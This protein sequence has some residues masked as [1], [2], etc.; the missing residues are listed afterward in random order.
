M[1]RN[2]IIFIILSIVLFTALIYSNSFNVPFQFDDVKR[3]VGIKAAQVLN[4]KEIF[5][6]SKTR[7]LLYL[8][9]ALNFHFGHL[10]VFGYHVFNLAVHITAS[11][12]VFLLCLYIFNSPKLAGFNFKEHRYILSFFSALI[13][14][15]HPLQTQAVTYIWQR[16]ESMAGM[17]YFLSLVLYA[18]FR[19]SQIYDGDK[20]Q[21][22]L[23]YLTCL[24]S[25][26]L[27]SLTKPTSITLPI[28]ILL[29]EATFFS[30]N[31]EDFKKSLKFLFPILLL[32]LFPLLLAKFDAGENKGVGIRF[33]SYYMPY[34]YTKLRVLANAFRLMF[35]PVGQRLEYDFIL[36]ASLIKPISTFYSLIFHAALII[37]AIAAFKRYPFLSFAI[38][39]FYLTLIGTTLL[40]LDQYHI[41]F[42]HYLYLTLF[43]YAFILPILILNLTRKMHVGKKWCVVALVIFTAAYSV[44]SYSRNKVWQT[45]ISLWEDAV[46]KSPCS[47]RANYTLGVYYFR[48][49]RF[50]EALKRYHLALQYRPA[51]AEAYYRLGEYYFG[52][53]DAEKAVSNYKRALKIKPDF[54]EAYLNL[55]GVYLYLNKYKDA[56]LC[57]NN[58]LRFTEDSDYIRKINTVIKELE[59]YE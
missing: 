27:C 51:Y 42:E 14:A 15:V 35:L 41:F 30:K 59:R 33:T 11:L 45:E 47:A 22:N 38:T 55:G 9:L 52:F 54:F 34:Y 21:K 19:L 49:K 7:F 48:A 2:Y 17:F 57:Y 39:W 16:G 31:S 5:Q 23:L 12:I 56:R 8:T 18:K 26:I 36:S 43:G 44:A 4:I 6:Y 46:R 53:G 50:K 28:A 24:G 58:A 40:Y 10:N 1:R 13:F 25:I 29:C 3:V 37:A 32:I 20:R